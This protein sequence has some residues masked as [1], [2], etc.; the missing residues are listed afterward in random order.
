M[1]LFLSID[2]AKSIHDAAIPVYGNGWGVQ[3]T[4]H[5][6]LAPVRLFVRTISIRR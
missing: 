5:P 2:F 6:S 4:R 3:P 1:I